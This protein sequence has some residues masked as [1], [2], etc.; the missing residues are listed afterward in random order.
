MVELCGGEGTAKSELLLNVTAH[1]ILP[2]AW[3]GTKLPGRNAEVVYIST[4][5]KFDLL[6]LVAILEGRIEQACNPD[7]SLDG[8]P[9]CTTE[10]KKLVKSCLSRAHIL[11]CNSSAELTTT[12]QSLKS[13][14]RNHPEVCMLILDNVASFYWIDRCESGIAN[15]AA[16][17][18]HGQRL[19]VGAFREL[20]QEYHLIAFAAKPHLFGRSRFH[21]K[22]SSSGGV[23]P[24]SVTAKY[25]TVSCRSEAHF[26]C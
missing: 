21:T 18:E 1:C 15:M 5:Y 16:A 22:G 23:Q 24:Y 26:C 17:T 13:F 8:M 19:W 25:S 2:K 20:V 4:D 11:Y 10:Y 6:R 3:S 9:E 7:R 12:L 14:V